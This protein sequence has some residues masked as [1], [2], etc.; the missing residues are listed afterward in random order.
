[1]TDT[2]KVET[3]AIGYSELETKDI[4]FAGIIATTCLAA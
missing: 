3:E 1:M 4:E 2:P